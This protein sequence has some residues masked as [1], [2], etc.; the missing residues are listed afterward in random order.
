[1]LTGAA[2]LKLILGFDAAYTNLTA[3]DYILPSSDTLIVNNATGEYAHAISGGAK[4]QN[5]S[6][7]EVMEQESI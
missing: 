5:H 3:F 7:L 6:K 2:T 4:S 1:M